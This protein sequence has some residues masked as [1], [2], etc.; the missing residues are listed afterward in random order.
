MRANGCGDGDAGGRMVVGD[1]GI[2]LGLSGRGRA[3]AGFGAD[4][5]YESGGAGKMKAESSNLTERP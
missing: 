3:P 1:V 4:S 5:E 2:S